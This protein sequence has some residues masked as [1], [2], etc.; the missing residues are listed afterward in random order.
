M[1]ARHD[2][3]TVMTSD[4]RR[5]KISSLHLV[6]GDVIVLPKNKSTLQCDAVLLRGHVIVNESSLTGESLPVTKT[7]LHRPLKDDGMP[8]DAVKNRRHMLYAGTSVL[9]TRYYGDEDVL[10]VVMETGFQTNKGKLLRSILF[11]KPVGLEFK[12]DALKFVTVLGEYLNI[13]YQ[14]T[15]SYSNTHLLP[16]SPAFWNMPLYT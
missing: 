16:Y 12:K 3:V 2:D 13:S 9:Q 6:P 4:N 10:A 14:V 7:A 11:P 8:Y 5:E 15:T 1:I